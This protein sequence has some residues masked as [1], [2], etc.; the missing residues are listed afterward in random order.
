MFSI[1]FAARFSSE[2]ACATVTAVDGDGPTL[3]AASSA[4]RVN[5]AAVEHDAMHCFVTFC[6]L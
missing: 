1:V 3:T 4:G 2:H 5:D 6:F